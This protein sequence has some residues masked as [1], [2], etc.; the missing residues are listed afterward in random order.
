MPG[1]VQPAR[2]PSVKNLQA[3]AGPAA[4]ESLQRVLGDEG[5]AT[6]RDACASVDLDWRDALTPEQVLTV[7]KA[8]AARPGLHGALGTSLRIR[9]ETYLALRKEA[10]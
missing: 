5:F 10:S 9:C 6:W 4:M 2:V 3:P 8:L 1:F 7:A